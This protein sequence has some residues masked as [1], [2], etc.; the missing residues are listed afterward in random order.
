M[1]IVC[2]PRRL[3]LGERLVGVDMASAR[4]ILQFREGVEHLDGRVILRVRVRH[5]LV[6]MAGRTIWEQ[7]WRNIG[8]LFVVLLMAGNAGR[9]RGAEIVQHISC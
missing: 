9:R 4:A 1:F 3:D 2:V 6:G 5:E 8:D 7:S